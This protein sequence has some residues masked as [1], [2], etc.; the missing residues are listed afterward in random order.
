MGQAKKPWYLLNGGPR[1]HGK[2]GGWVI[3]LNIH[4]S[5][6]LRA[7]DFWLTDFL[8]GFCHQ[9]FCIWIQEAAT[10]QPQQQDFKFHLCQTKSTVESALFVDV[11]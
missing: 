11:C 10:A 4:V 8:Q 2:N 1:P 3:E 7:V 9:A 5:A 6:V